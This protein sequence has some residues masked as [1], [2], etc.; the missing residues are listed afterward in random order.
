MALSGVDGNLDIAVLTVAS[1]DV[2]R[3][4]HN[5][6][7]EYRPVWHPDGTKITYTSHAGNDSLD[8]APNLFTVDL[9]TGNTLQNTDVGDAVWSTQWTPGDSTVLATTLADLDT[10]RLV[11]VNPSRRATTGPL[12]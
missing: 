10:V 8:S 2:Q 11:K 12:A 4:T 5:P 1:G 6:K 7:A 9:S 3:V